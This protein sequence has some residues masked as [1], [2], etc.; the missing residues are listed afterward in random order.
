MSPGKPPPRTNLRRNLRVPVRVEVQPDTGDSSHGY[1][2]NVSRTGLGL[3]SSEAYKLGLRLRLRFRFSSSDPWIE[4]D[5][6]VIWCM[7]ESDLSPGMNYCE[8]GVRFLDVP[9]QVED[10]LAAFVACLAQDPDEDPN[11]A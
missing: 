3:Q 9:P 6:E 2:I 7:C 5:A 10:Q 4:L 11:R 8:L 1:A